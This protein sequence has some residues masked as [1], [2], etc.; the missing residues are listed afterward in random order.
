MIGNTIYDSQSKQSQ[1]EDYIGPDD[2]LYCGRC[3]EPKEEYYPKRCKC[4]RFRDKH[5]RLCACDRE[6]IK[7]ENQERE[8]IRHER[9]V[10]RL[11]EQCFTDRHQYDMTFEASTEPSVQLEI[12]RKYTKDWDPE[13]RKNR[14]LLFWGDVGN[15]KSYLAA[16][17]ANAL[18]EKEVSVRMLSLGQILNADIEKRP[19]IICDLPKYDLLILDDFG[20]ERSTGYGQ[21]IVFQVID[22]RCLSGKPMIITTNLSLNTLKNPKDLEHKRIYDRILE[23]CIPISFKGRNL[24][25]RN[26]VEKV[27]EFRE[28]IKNDSK[29]SPYDP[30]YDGGGNAAHE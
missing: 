15:G 21:E 2:L 25:Y 13:V 8:I 14:G 5:Y 29:E 7:K 1:Y 27:K 20:M 12:C 11:R 4:L 6:R 18:I 22:S 28:R 9:E 19:R 26:H 24:R 17:I 30:D 23:V 10:I 3:H 16:C